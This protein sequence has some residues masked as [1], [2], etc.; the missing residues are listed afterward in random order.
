MSG[1]SFSGCPIRI[2]LGNYFHL[3]KG[4]Q[5]ISE[6]PATPFARRK[7]IPFHGDRT[8]LSIEG[9]STGNLHFLWPE[10]PSLSRRPFQG[11]LKIPH[12][13]L[14]VKHFSDDFLTQCANSC[15]FTLCSAIPCSCSHSVWN[16][17]GLSTR[18]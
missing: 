7:A 13:R 6:F 16:V 3:A 5:E 11:G 9:T 1:P 10:P 15:V 18:S 4:Q 12:Q 14:P 8:V 2:G 17:P